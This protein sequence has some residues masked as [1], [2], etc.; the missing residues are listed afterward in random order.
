MKG[1]ILAGGANT[2]LYPVTRAVCKQLLPVYDTPM[3]Y[4]PLATLMQA[5]VRDILLISRPEWIPLF[6]RLLGTG[7]Q[8]GISLSYAEQDEP[9]GVA[10]ALRVGADFVGA[11]EVALVL[12]DNLFYG[13]AD[14]LPDAVAKLDG[15]TLFG[16]EVSDPRPWGVLDTDPS[17]RIRSIEEKPVAPKSQ[18]AVTGLYLYDARAVEFAADLT[19]SARG[20]IEITDVNNAYVREGRAQLVRMGQGTA[21]LDMGTHDLLLD[22]SNF[23]Q[24]LERRQGV[25][26]ACVEEI[27]LRMGFI[28]AAQARALGKAQ[29]NSPYGDYIVEAAKRYGA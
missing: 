23:V 29:A 2:R 9:R 20:E 22:A 11:D 4:Y 12:G 24:V 19:P 26:I 17:G 13:I 6:Q 7:E 28:D 15:C 5:G 1:I 21:W 8:L 16:Y 25:R 27:A 18:W 14:L 3:I 10:D